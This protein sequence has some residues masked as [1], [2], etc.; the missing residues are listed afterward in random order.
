MASHV[1]S[2]QRAGPRQLPSQA[3]TQANTTSARAVRGRLRVRPAPASASTRKGVGGNSSAEST[4]LS[5]PMPEE[6]NQSANMER[7]VAEARTG[8][9]PAWRWRTC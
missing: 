9:K 4:G 7:I 5:D 8:S 3:P 6:V 1:S 2:T